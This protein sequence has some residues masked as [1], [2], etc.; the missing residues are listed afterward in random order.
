MK[1]INHE[2]DSDNCNIDGVCNH[3]S[4]DA[5]YLISLLIVLNCNPVN[6]YNSHFKKV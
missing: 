5:N 3:D 1:T 4:E 2:N 6:I